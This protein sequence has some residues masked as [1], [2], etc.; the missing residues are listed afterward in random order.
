MD[1]LTRGS[2]FHS[3]Q[4]RLLS[5]LRTLG[6]LPVNSENLSSAVSVADRVLDDVAEIYREELAPA[7]PSIWEREIEDI[8]WD[9][10]GWLRAATVAA[11]GPWVP[12]WFELSFGLPKVTERDPE[13]S[14]DPIELPGGFRVRGAID[15][16]E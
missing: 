6:L 13:S 15:M 16:I 2:L 4:F 5:E 3:T 1:A 14:V 8:R 9:L 12:K 11:D 7:I 10:R